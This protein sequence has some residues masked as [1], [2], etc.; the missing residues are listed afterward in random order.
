AGL[1]VLDRQL[2]DLLRGAHHLGGARERAGVD[3][4]VE[5]AAAG[6]GTAA[7]GVGRGG[8]P[9]RARRSRSSC[10]ISTSS[11]VTSKSASPLSVWSG[12]RLIPARSVGSRRRLTPGSLRTGA[13][14]P[15]ARWAA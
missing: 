3:R 14:S 4:G 15:A 8:G 10:A 9:A 13:I 5:Q 12:S 1:G 6:A 11:K 7:A 2:H